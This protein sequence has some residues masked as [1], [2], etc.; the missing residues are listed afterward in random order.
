MSTYDADWVRRYFDEYGIK[1]WLRWDESPVERIKYFV[2]LHYL[3][4]CVARDDRVLE[5]GAGAGRFTRELAAITNRIVVAD[6][7][8]GQLRLNRENAE[9]LDFA[10]SVERWVECDACHLRPHFK[11]A[12]FDVVVCIGGLLSYVFEQRDAALR[13]LIR[14]TRP[15]GMLLFGAMSLWGAVHQYLPGVLDVEIERNRAIIASGDL[16]PETIGS[17]RHYC[18]MFRS[19]E[20]RGLLAQS[21]LSIEAVSASD[22]LAVNWGDALDELSEDD[23]KWQHLIEMEIEASREA[24]CLDMGT[25]LIAVCRK[26]S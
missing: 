10:S 12:E 3:K 24:G 8:S 20:L 2:H 9:R 4:Q 7:S 16:T 6:L 11:D 17:G 21:G 14:V 19:D 15:G 1:E 22:C 26:P 25:H 13:E 23:P 18:H 5:I